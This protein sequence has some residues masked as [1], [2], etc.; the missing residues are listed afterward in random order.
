MEIICIKND[1]QVAT[2]DVVRFSQPYKTVRRNFGKCSH[3][4]TVN[5]MYDNNDNFLEVECVAGKI[6]KV[7]FGKVCREVKREILHILAYYIEW[8]Q[9]SQNGNTRKK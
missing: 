8:Q 9:K 4:M 5:L 7:L 2:N 3:D 1:K 6:D